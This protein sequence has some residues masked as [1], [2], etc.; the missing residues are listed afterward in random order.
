MTGMH[1]ARRAVP[2]GGTAAGA[3]RRWLYAGSGERADLYQWRWYWQAN[4]VEH[5]PGAQRP[6]RSG[7]I[8]PSQSLLS[9]EA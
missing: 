5:E 2:F 6:L 8:V 3:G 4:M 9:P 1:D 7:A